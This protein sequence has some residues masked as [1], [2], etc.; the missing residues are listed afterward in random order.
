[1]TSSVLRASD[2]QYGVGIT[3][4][5]RLFMCVCVCVCIKC[6]YYIVIL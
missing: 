2:I 4:D 5:A 6:A 3:A 1:M